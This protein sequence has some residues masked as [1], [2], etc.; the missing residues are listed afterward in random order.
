M[1]YRP[2]KSRNQYLRLFSWKSLFQT[3]YLECT[4]IFTLSEMTVTRV[5]LDS[6]SNVCFPISNGLFLVVVT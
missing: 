5:T 2:Y 4:L 6:L 1:P 3:K